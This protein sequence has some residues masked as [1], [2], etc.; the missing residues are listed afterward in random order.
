[1]SKDSSRPLV[2][3]TNQF[4]KREAML[5][6]L[7]CGDVRLTI[8]VSQRTSDDGLG[9]WLIEA[10]ARQSAERPPI[11]EPGATRDEALRAVGRAWTAK[12]GAHG[13]PRLDWDA[14]AEAMQSVRAI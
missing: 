12:G 5:Y 10:H 13:F 6:D 3:I 14:V 2:R 11:N 8:Q 7:A 9:G 1:M 4:R